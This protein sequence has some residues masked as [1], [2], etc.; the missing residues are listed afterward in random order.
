MQIDAIEINGFQAIAPGS[1]VRLDEFRTRNIFVGPNNAGKSILFRCIN[2]IRT[3]ILDWDI[4]ASVA[5]KASLGFFRL[6]G[7]YGS[8]LW[9]QHLTEVGEI[10]ARIELSLEPFETE[11]YT[12]SGEFQFLKIAYPD[13]S[14]AILLV[15]ILSSGHLCITPYLDHNMQWYPAIL[16][17]D[18]RPGLP[19]RYIYTDSYVSIKFVDELLEKFCQFLKLF[20]SS[21]RVFD[22]VRSLDRPSGF[23]RTE[24]GS[25]ILF[26]LLKRSGAETVAE[27]NTWASFA[28]TV[29]TEVN[30]LLVLSGSP[31]IQGIKIIDRN[32]AK[33]QDPHIGEPLAS[34]PYLGIEINDMF[35]ELSS[36]G[37][38]MAELI[39]IMIAIA[40]DRLCKKIYFLEEPES[41]LHPGLLR[42][43]I[44]QLS[45]YSN[46]QLFINTHSNV[47]LDCLT[48]T[49][50]VFQV[51][52][53]QG[54]TKISECSEIAQ[55]SGA[56]DSLGIRAS[57]LFQ[58][59][60]A[61]WIEG[62]SDRLYIRE[63]LMQISVEKKLALVEGSDYAF[64]MYGGKNLSHF[65]FY[66]E[67]AEEQNDDD[68]LGDELFS[69][70]KISRYSAVI[71]DR[72]LSPTDDSS[73]LRKA[74]QRIMDQ[75][76]KD[77]IHRFCAL[78]Q[79]REIELDIPNRILLAAVCR[80]C[81]V[82][83][84]ETFTFA[85]NTSFTNE[86]AGHLT[87]T[88]SEAKKIAKR[89]AQK[90]VSIAEAVCNAEE[91]FSSPQW[92]YDLFDFIVRARNI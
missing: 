75:S 37:S 53:E 40:N 6:P 90:K 66:D 70:I 27:Q 14:K 19:I 58:S 91:T 20:A 2:L 71:M 48:K 56:I 52:L 41:H 1:P 7:S 18:I 46:L 76:S 28:R 22:A 67:E 51:R 42:R 24:D 23:G 32:A 13:L 57:S 89:L 15:R 65:Q 50:K 12:V 39:M 26:D 84:K 8:D 85:E 73:K 62:P 3:A 45:T 80:A 5:D 31:E 60:C 47:I 35:V 9:W 63:M 33:R 86:I 21:I 36:L 43:F 10:T 92:A 16:D 30:K 72:D 34:Q 83:P 88:T 82:K 74:K 68:S 81:G 54:Q 79:H 11:P 44:A 29:R 55:L 69:M 61:I 87:K 25:G 78:T 4:E 59:N 64:I 17:G 77:T 38:G 49:D